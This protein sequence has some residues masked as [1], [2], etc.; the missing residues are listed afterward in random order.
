MRLAIRAIRIAAAFLFLAPAAALAQGTSAPPPGLAIP[1][2]MARYQVVFLVPGARF[3]APMDSAA[4]FALTAKHLEFIK[5]MLETRVFLLAGPFLD[6]G[7][8]Q[9]MA[10]VVAATP[11]EAR[12]IVAADPEVSSGRLAIEAHPAMLPSLDAVK[13]TY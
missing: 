7:R 11:E 1:K 12:R 6:G 8:I 13:V 5:Q 2:N 10:V 3:S 4:A 9:G